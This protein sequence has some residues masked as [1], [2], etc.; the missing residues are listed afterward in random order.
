MLR[1]IPFIKPMAPTLAKAPPEGS[2]W[3]HEVK[4]DGWRM[5]LH[6]EQGDAALYSKNG[7]D[8]TKRF[9]ALRDTI[10]G[11]PVK[12]AIIDCELV[13]CD[14]TG[15]PNFPTLMEMGNKAPA[16]CL[17]CFDLLS[18]D[19]ARIMPLPLSQRKA[20]LADV[21]AAA[22]DEHLQFSGD[23]SDPIKLLDTCQRMNLEGIVS[24]RRESA[25]RPGPTHDWLK[26]K[27]ATWRAENNHRYD[28]LFAKRAHR[29]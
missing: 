2:D 13:A 15:M 21:L 19:G 22:D 20:M 9:G 25:Y 1:K 8:Y 14:D 10:E 3:L 28:E 16:L 6:V 27:T 24:K 4:F 5:Q 29:A 18:L 7:T 17:W 12:S 11:I 23:F 26:I